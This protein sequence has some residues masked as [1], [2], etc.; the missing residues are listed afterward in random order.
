DV[1]VLYYAVAPEA[2]KQ[3]TTEGLKPLARRMVHLS[4]TVERAL[5]AGKVRT[6]NPVV[7]V[8]DV[9]RAR[10]MGIKILKASDRV[11]LAPEIPPQCVRILESQGA[12]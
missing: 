8:V 4:P 5:E 1:D 6:E 7:L 11:Y 2:V 9:R 10:E 3:A 12:N